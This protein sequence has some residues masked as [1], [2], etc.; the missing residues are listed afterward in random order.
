MWLCGY[1]CLYVYAQA[2]VL[3]RASCSVALLWLGL[4]L[5]GGLLR[6]SDLLYQKDAAEV[7]SARIPASCVFAQT[8]QKVRSGRRRMTGMVLGWV[9]LG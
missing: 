8:A 9:K 1:V 2:R 4:L 7:L 5:L 6:Q 3:R